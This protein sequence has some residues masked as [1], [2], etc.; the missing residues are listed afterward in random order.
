MM[1]NCFIYTQ[2]SHREALCEQHRA[3]PATPNLSSI[4][5]SAWTEP[6]QHLDAPQDAPFRRDLGPEHSGQRCVQDRAL[7]Q[8]LGCLL[9][10]SVWTE[11]AQ[12]V[13]ATRGD[14]DTQPCWTI[15]P[16]LHITGEAPPLRQTPPTAATPRNTAGGAPP[17]PGHVPP[18]APPLQPP[19][20][21]R[22]FLAPPTRGT[23]QSLSP[24]HF[25]RAHQAAPAETRLYLVMSRLYL[26]MSR[27]CPAPPR[28]AP[29]PSRTPAA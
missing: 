4:Y 3:D 22:P 23:D 13:N 7:P 2:R 14:G 26:V 11:S 20:E 5:T 10:T 21:T 1:A 16:R 12:H 19:A 24:P 6:G 18:L 9:Y 15:L 27:P 8:V 29:P 25:D 17:L 28:L